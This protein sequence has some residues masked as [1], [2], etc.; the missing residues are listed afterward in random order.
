MRSLCLKLLYYFSH[1][2]NHY[3]YQ[4][5]IS[6][7]KTSNYLLFD[8]GYIVYL[9]NV[10]CLC[11]AWFSCNKTHATTYYF[12]L[13]YPDSALAVYSALWIDIWDELVPGLLPSIN[14]SP[15]H[16]R[17]KYPWLKWW[18][19]SKPHNGNQHSGR[20]EQDWGGHF[21]SSRPAGVSIYNFIH[22]VWLFYTVGYRIIDALG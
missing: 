10:N 3:V 11:R 19:A 9:M 15:N 18:P 22:T 7:Y 5:T 17:N 6:L 14:I 1:E 20:T 12:C 4:A 21:S 13:Y 2:R 8:L 16:W